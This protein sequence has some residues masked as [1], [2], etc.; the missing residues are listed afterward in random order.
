MTEA[1]TLQPPDSSPD[2]LD[3]W[4]EIAAYL[5]RDVTTVQRWEKREDMPV[6]RHQH[7]RMGSVYAF[8]H[9]LDAWSQQR[10]SSPAEPSDSSVVVDVDRPAPPS[11]DSRSR[12]DSRWPWAAAA[13]L[14]AGVVA[15]RTWG[16]DSSDAFADARF[17][18]LTNS[19]GISKAAALSHDGRYAAF[20]SDRDGRVDVWITQIGTGQ[21]YNRT[22]DAPRELVNAAIRTVDF[23]PDGSLVTFWV[24]RTDQ[25]GQ[26]SIDVWAAPVLGGAPKPYLEGAAE[27]P[28]GRQTTH[29]SCITQRPTAIR[30]SCGVPRRRRPASSSSRRRTRSTATSRPG[31]LTGGSSISS[32]VFQ[33]GR[34]CGASL[35]RAAL[36]N[37]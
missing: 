33:A 37:A 20:L 1:S 25:A 24:R 35:R 14:V 9:E 7:D 22:A 30:C 13:V 4:K 18:A 28:T 23:S 6:H 15:W 26:V 8:R 5:R 16:G 31:P 27:V 12:H 3:S 29:G 32:R 36:P 11:S 2:R 17:L 10:S 19:G 34:T 21:F